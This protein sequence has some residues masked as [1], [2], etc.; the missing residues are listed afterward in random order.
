MKHHA[1]HCS[2]LFLVI[3]VRA[4][5]CAKPGIAWYWAKTRGSR[6]FK[7][8]RSRRGMTAWGGPA[9]VP[10]DRD[11]GE[12]K[13]E[14]QAD[15]EFKSTNEIPLHTI[16]SLMEIRVHTPLKRIVLYRLVRGSAWQAMG[17]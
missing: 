11:Y 17:C 3:L 13:M 10:I 4:L 6:L 12:A 7:I 1:V 14:I 5:P 8:L 9:L 2:L 15:R 16:E